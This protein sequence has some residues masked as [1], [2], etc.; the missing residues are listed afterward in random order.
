MKL[1]KIVLAFLVPAF[2]MNACSKEY[3]VENNGLKLPA[4]NWEFS[5]GT[6]QYTGNMDTAYIVSTATSKELH[7]EGTSTPAGQNF[8]MVLYATDFKAGTYKAS[9]FQSTFN[10]TTTAKTIYQ[11]DQL[12]GEF[13]VTL[14][15]FSS[16]LVIGTFAGTAKDTANKLIQLTLGKFKATLGDGIATAVSSGV[17]GDSSGNCKP[18]LLN[19]TFTQG[20]AMSTSNSVQAQVVVATAGSYSIS[21][22]TVNGVTFSSAGTFNNTGSQTVVLNATGTPLQAGDQTFTMTYGNSQCSFKVTFL[23]GVGPSDDYFPLK[24]NSNWTFGQEANPSADS[25]YTKVISYSP[26]F[27]GN[28]YSTI[29]EASIRG[30]QANDSLY[31]RK[32]PG[33]YYQ[34]VDFSKIFSFDNPVLG[35]FLFL[36]DNVAA[37]ATWQSA[38]VSG[39]IGGAPFSGYVKMTLLEKAVP[40]NLGNFPFPDVIK[41]KYEFF[42]SG[43]SLPLQT[44][45]R[46]FAKNVGEIRTNVSDANGNSTTF[47][48]GSYQIF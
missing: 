17:L 21:T 27:N 45:E 47:V 11:A 35:E 39:T 16:N 9:L 44:Q 48:V 3:S 8:R 5:N 20:I 33:N 42:L 14:T 37:N 22:N 2:L 29:T 43:I 7:L 28:T 26:A 1:V 34:Y 41:V 4:G 31:F 6:T 30:A 13:I 10:Y 15:T 23:P 40:V 25:I 38:T 36:K 19:G 12:V 46:W 32:S 24:V 18:V